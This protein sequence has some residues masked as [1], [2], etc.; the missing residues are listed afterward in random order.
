METAAFAPARPGE[1]LAHI[2]VIRGLALFGVL[3]MNVHF[4]FRGPMERF[5][6]DPHPFE[7]FWNGFTDNALRLLVEGKAMTLFSMLFGVG[8]ALQLERK[9]ASG[10]GFWGFAWRRMGALFG[11]GML[12]VLLLWYGDVLALYAVDGVLLFAFLKRR[13][14][15]L[16]IWLACMASLMALAV[17]VMVGNRLAHIGAFQADQAKAAGELQARVAWLID[18][19]LQPGWMDGTVFRITHYLQEAGDQIA[20]IILAFFNL[21]LGLVI[22]RSGLLRAPA[23]HLATLRRAAFW[24]FALGLPAGLLRLYSRDLYEIVIRT[25]GWSKGVLF[26]AALLQVF[27]H[28]ILALAYGAA[29]LLLWQRPR[30]QAF[31][32]PFAFV[33]RMALTH[34][35]AQ[36]LVMGAVFFGWGLGL[37]G[38][39]GPL[40]GL[41]MCV[42]LYAAQI[43]A[44]RWWLQRFQ[45]GPVEWLW[46]CLSYA[47]LQPFRLRAPAPALDASILPTSP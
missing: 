26:P 12:H 17:L 41:A 9:E 11:F 34:Y 42:V 43:A 13:T 36:S 2:D 24:L 16:H 4:H 8:L 31:L 1:R 27:S 46:R 28:H 29:L 30:W 35:L 44:S 32:R 14:R 15:T 19:Y 3:V 7:G 23:E 39:V 37:Y 22:W 18:G 25:G 33:G 38:K 20:G 21:F 5:I 40:A 10:G 6:I 47:R 45:F